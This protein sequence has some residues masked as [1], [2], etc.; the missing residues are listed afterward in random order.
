M[1]LMKSRRRKNSMLSSVNGVVGNGSTLTSY[2]NIIVGRPNGQWRWINDPASESSRNGRE[3]DNRNLR[4]TGC[5]VSDRRVHFAADGFEVTQ[6][7]DTRLA[8]AYR[9]VT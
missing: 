3:P 2:L 4:P 5:N 6:H 9:G 1:P 8:E 7:V